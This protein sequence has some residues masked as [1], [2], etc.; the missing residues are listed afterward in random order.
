MRL[1]SVF[2]I[3]FLFILL[4]TGL[5]ACTA[6]AGHPAGVA[7]S[8]GSTG[9]FDKADGLVCQGVVEANEVSINTKIPGRIAKISVEE[10]AEVKSG[11]VLVEIGSDEL[12]AKEEQAIALV[13]SAKAAYDAAKG[14][15]AA[16]DSTLRKAENG[17][18]IQEIAQAQAYFDLM[19]KTYERV[20]KL[21][22]K[23]AVSAQKRDEVQTQLEV[24]AQQLSMAKEGARSEDKSGAQALV[25][26]ALAMQE[27]AKG[28]LEQA[29][30]GL[31]E[32]RAYLRDT[33]ILSPIDGTVTVINSHEG[34]LVSTGMSIA[35]VSDIRNSW[36]EVK[37]KET[38]LQ[39]IQLRQS[40]DVKVTSYPDTAFRG[41]VV[42][43]NQ[44]P[45]FATKRSTNDNGDFDILSYGVKIEL[46]NADRILRPGMTA[47]IQFKS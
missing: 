7:G 9:L 42:R 21:F 6:N 30:G 28:K 13:E 1:K 20:Q 34:E 16:A 8:G 26:Q 44:K 29:E 27:A 2:Y 11:E 12:K 18:R 17:A 39:K 41:T 3:M 24:A 4:L 35:T 14:Q 38:D 37:V 23:G 5:S 22:E 43:I 10:G 31:E 40:V 15:V 36:V 46:D 19:Q 32:V 33:R 47:F 45:D 25:A